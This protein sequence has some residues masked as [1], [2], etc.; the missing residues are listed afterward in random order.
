MG[1]SKQNNLRENIC[2]P[3]VQ[4][5]TRVYK[6]RSIAFYCT[7]FHSNAKNCKIEALCSDVCS[8][9]LIMLIN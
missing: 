1:T 4:E 9:H 7:G 2:I 3:Q 6:S 8:L 5:V